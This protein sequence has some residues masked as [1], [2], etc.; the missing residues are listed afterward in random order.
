MPKPDP[1]PSPR[2]KIS[3]M[4]SVSGVK[5]VGDH[6]YRRWKTQILLDPTLVPLEGTQPCG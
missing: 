2:K 6:C 1:T 4:K 3:S 5:R